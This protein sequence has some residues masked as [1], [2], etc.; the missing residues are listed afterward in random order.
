MNWDAI[1][2][3]LRQKKTALEKTRE[4]SNHPAV[5]AAGIHRKFRNHTFSRTYSKGAIRPSLHW[6]DLPIGRKVLEVPLYLQM[7]PS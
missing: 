3:I 5:G 1:K 4:I 6:I 7:E 2:K